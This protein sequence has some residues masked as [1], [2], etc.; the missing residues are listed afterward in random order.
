MKE[1]FTNDDNILS[2]LCNKIRDKTI[3][4]K[5]HNNPD[6]DSHLSCLLLKHCFKIY[7]IDNV[8]ILIQRNHFTDKDYLIKYDLWNESDYCYY[9]NEQDV[10]DGYVCYLDHH[11]V[12][13]FRNLKPVM[14][15][16]HHP[17]NSSND[18]KSY[19]YVNK[20]SISTTYLV[21]NMFKSA[22]TF[23]ESIKKALEMTIIASYFDTY[24]FLSTKTIENEKKDI[25][26]YI[27]YI[28]FDVEKIKD[29]VLNIITKGQL[30]DKYLEFVLSNEKTYSYE[31]ICVRSSYITTDRNISDKS[32][33]SFMK[34]LVGCQYPK[35]DYYIFI[36][37]NLNKVT[38]DIIYV[39]TS[40]NYYVKIQ[41][42]NILSRGNDI[43]P[44][45]LKVLQ[46]TKDSNI[47]S[48]CLNLIEKLRVEQETVS[49]MES[50]TS[51]NIA[52][53]ICNYPNA[54]HIIK[55]SLITYSDEAKIM[56]GVSKT[57][58]EK[59]SVYSENTAK[60]M[61]KN[62]SIRFSSD[63]GIG[64]TG[65]I[66]RK[67]P[68]HETSNVGEIYTSIYNCKNNTYNTLKIVYID[69]AKSRQVVKDEVTDIVLK[70]LFIMKT[71]KE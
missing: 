64:I 4:L 41:S 63:Y 45:F 44:G 58:I 47:Q 21:Y 19:L 62:V 43:I 5:G 71:N 54:S 57:T 18:K 37:H 66:G 61:S 36:I 14:V 68:V 70:E 38:T 2:G 13:Q 40:K 11:D 48:I 22:I 16:D 23:Q 9:D 6:V 69:N 25:E 51:G 12:S 50:C 55:G 32:I 35:C 1:N 60:E 3:Y 10:K 53:S 42:S 17:D 26:K 46:H 65:T 33:S 67:D 31:E 20:K 49:T 15:I 24:A 27:D 29:D 56:F 39:N 8:K 7:K 52:N 59:Y 30:D 28:S 34:T